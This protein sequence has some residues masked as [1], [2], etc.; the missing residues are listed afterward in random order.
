MNLQKLLNEIA[1]LGIEKEIIRY[2]AAGGSLYTL[3]QKTIR[4][5]PV[6]FSSPTGDHT[7]KDD[8]TRFTITLYYLDRLLE[9]SSN[10]ID[11]FSTSVEQ[12][13]NIVKSIA[14][15][16]EVIDVSEEYRI[17]NFTETERMSD[18]VAGAYTTIDVTVMNTSL[19]VED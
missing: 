14:E 12:L 6:L 8:T 19:C 9:D 13:K 5:Y 3:S 17:R 11:I 1:R 16:D 7:V 18:R 2:S 15:I 4:N 10:D